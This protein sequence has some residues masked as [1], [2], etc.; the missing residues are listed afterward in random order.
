MR[1]DK[2]QNEL[3]I[4]LAS[5]F[6]KD[7]AVTS[8]IFQKKETHGRTCRK[9]TI[10]GVSYKK[11]RRD[12]FYSGKIKSQLKANILRYFIAGTEARVPDRKKCSGRGRTDHN[13]SYMQLPVSVMRFAYLRF[14]LLQ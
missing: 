2:P 8:P 3:F 5:S 11:H 10:F 14:T 12:F 9:I 7:L 6:Q 1:T 4:K 13:I